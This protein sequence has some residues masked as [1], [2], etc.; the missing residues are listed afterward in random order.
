M[1]LELSLKIRSLSQE[2]CSSPQALHV[3]LKTLSCPA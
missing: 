3:P 2:P 1:L